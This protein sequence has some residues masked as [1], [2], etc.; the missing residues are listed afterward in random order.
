MGLS[1]SA[2]TIQG[3]SPE[4]ASPAAWG[5]GGLKAGETSADLTLS[6]QDSLIYP[7]STLFSIYCV[8]GIV[9]SPGHDLEP[10]SAQARP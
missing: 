7:Q 8:L 2:R 1:W 5:E 6:T 3:L 9:P 10:Q 4:V